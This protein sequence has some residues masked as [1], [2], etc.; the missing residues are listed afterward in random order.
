MGREDA[1]NCKRIH[2]IHSDSANTKFKVE[3]G[4]NTE[5][6]AALAFWGLMHDNT[7]LRTENGCIFEE[8]EADDKPAAQEAN[9]ACGFVAVDMGPEI[10]SIGP[11]QLII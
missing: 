2:K 9:E 6:R 7:E 1:V 10:P 11:G 3:S 8:A 4:I 5:H